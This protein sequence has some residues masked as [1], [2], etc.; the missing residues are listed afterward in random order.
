MF[1]KRQI[2][3]WFD[4]RLTRRLVIV[5][6]TVIAAVLSLVLSPLLL[7]AALISDVSKKRSRWPR[8]RIIALVIGAL[9][10]E[11]CGMIVSFIVWVATG[12]GLIG[13]ERWRW[14]MQRGYMG[15]YTQAM[16]GLIT[17]VLGTTVE[18]RCGADLDEG[19]VVVVARHTSFFDALIPATMVSRRHKLL[20][21]HVVTHGLRYSPCIDIVGH[22]FPNRFIKRTPG[23]GSGE[24]GKIEQI[25]SLLDKRSAGV[26][27]PEGTFRNPAR[28]E[29][30][31]RRINRREP[32]LAARARALRHVLPPRAN[33][34]FAL[35][36]GAPNADLVVCTN[37]G[38]EPF[39]SI[40]EILAMPQPRDPIVVETWRI[41][42]SQIPTDPDGFTLWFF[43]LYEQID[44]W[45]AAEQSRS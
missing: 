13:T 42:R 10:I 17:M 15:F 22:R 25:G 29:R 36:T 41:A 40:K 45:V 44:S 6:L 2:A 43:D 1:T 27:F 24:L 23:E 31:I 9:T 18:W 14:H 37:T 19:P 11:T 21:H 20:A 34:T 28:F 30:V 3:G 38:L 33:G 26:I 32:A 39:G 8:L 16:F 35:L 4:Y 7:L 12:F 5:P